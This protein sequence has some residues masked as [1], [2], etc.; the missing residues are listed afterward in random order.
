M[1]NQEFYQLFAAAQI[2]KPFNHKEHKETQRFLESIKS[3]VSEGGKHFPTRRGRRLSPR[4]PSSKKANH[5]GAQRTQR[6]YRFQKPLCFFVFFVVKGFSDSRQSSH[7]A[8]RVFRLPRDW[9]FCRPL[10][11]SSSSIPICSGLIF[12]AKPCIFLS[13]CCSS[14]RFCCSSLSALL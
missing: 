13:V 10:S 2:G 14:F 3:W 8:R 11:S 12:R 7:A 4:S 9:P 5:K 1:V 6:F